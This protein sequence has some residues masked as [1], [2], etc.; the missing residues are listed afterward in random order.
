MPSIVELP[1]KIVQLIKNSY[2]VYA[3]CDLPTYVRRHPHASPR[4]FIP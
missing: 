3:L 4:A 1:S 2:N